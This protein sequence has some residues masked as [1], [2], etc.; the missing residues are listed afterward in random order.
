VTSV[1]NLPVQDNIRFGLGDIVIIGFFSPERLG[2]YI[3]GVGPVISFPTATDKVLGSGKWSAG[4]SII[5]GAQRQRWLAAIIAFNIC[6]FAG[7]SDQ[8]DVN[9]T[10][11]DIV[12]RYHLGNRWIFVSS[13]TIQ[14]DWYAK[15][16]NQWLVPIGGGI[17]RIWLAGGKGI[18]RGNPGLLQCRSTRDSSLLGVVV[19]LPGAVRREHPEVIPDSFLKIIRIPLYSEA[20]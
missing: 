15:D 11:V 19:A 13:P 1:I 17:G 3:W 10:Q 4:P 8:A 5:L 7:D 18:G 6:S 14:A 9:R 16:G 12:F 2:K 20:D